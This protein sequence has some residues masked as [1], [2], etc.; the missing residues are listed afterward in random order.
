MSASSPLVRLFLG[1]SSEGRDVA[2]H[3]QAELGDVCEVVRWDQSVFEPGGYT[4]DSLISTAKSVDFAVLVATP[5]DTTVSRGETKPSARD[6]IVLEFGLFAGALGRERTYLLAT[7]DLKL[8]TDVL[9]LTRLPY[10]AQASQ[11]AAVTAAALQVEE[12]VRSLGPLLQERGL[13][14]VRAP[15]TA[16]DRELDLLCA[17]AVAQGWTVKTNSPTTLRLLSPSRKPFTFAKGRPEASRVEL[18]RFASRL[19]A[20]G[21]RVNSS[22]RRPVGESPF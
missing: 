6:N 20:A 17:N 2:R 15:L 22:L 21:L 14:D 1:S 5:D 3:L 9:G 12:R 10:H 19:R 4:L 8:P 13:G 7:G 18:R 11:R 16:L